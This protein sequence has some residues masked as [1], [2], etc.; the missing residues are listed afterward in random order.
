MS[1]FKEQL[2]VSI[3]INDD[4]TYISYAS[5]GG[6]GVTTLSSRQDAEKYGVPTLMYKNENTNKWSFGANAYNR[7]RE[8]EGQL[9]DH[10][11]S[12]VTE[13]EAP[14]EDAKRRLGTFLAHALELAAEAIDKEY[15]NPS[16]T[17]LAICI[18]KVD[19]DILKHMENCVTPLKSVV[20]DIRFMTR[21]ECFYYYTLSQPPEIWRS[22]VL[23]VDYSRDGCTFSHLK[24]K[25]GVSYSVASIDEEEHFELLPFDE[26]NTQEMDL[27]LQGVLK[28]KLADSADSEGIRV[29]SIYLSGLNLEGSWAKNTLNYLCSGRRVFQGQNLYTKGACY[30]IRDQ[31][32][33]GFISKNFFFLSPDKVN[34]DVGIRMVHK[35]AEVISR[36]AEAGTSW[37][38]LKCETDVMLGENK[39][40]SIVLK[41]FPGGDEINHLIR[42]TAFPD[43]PKR[44]CRANIR[45]YMQEKN[46][47]TIEITD[48][49]LGELIPASG[50]MVTET[51]DLESC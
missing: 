10:I 25:R 8:G 17:A 49:G 33:R 34:Y 51:I 4:M 37:Y 6:R 15:M 40:V 45:M 26:E 14:D 29:S 47:L 46:I 21:S 50:I 43:R 30:A 28:E 9:Y 31:L 22:S 35:G 42:L 18:K 2:V 39:D 13:K 11:L 20:K 32:T 23:L 1:E 16:L 7:S 12:D 41:S 36:V 38:D 24:L 44:A 5:L 48:R 3:D 27:R 19:S